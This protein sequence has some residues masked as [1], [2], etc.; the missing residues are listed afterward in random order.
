M[1]GIQFSDEVADRLEAVYRGRDVAAQREDTLSRLA[2]K[3]GEHVLDIGSGPGFLCESIAEAVG[4]TGRV[5][6]VDISPDFVRRAGA[7]NRH[8]QLGYAVG[9]ATALDE[10]DAA[11]DVVVSTQVAEYV[12][13]IDAFCLEFRRVMKPGGRGLIIATD[14]DAVIWFSEHPER[15]ARMLKIWE[16]HCADPRLPRHLGPRLRAAGLELDG[17]SAFPLVNLRYEEGAYSHGVSGFIAG[18]AEKSGAV[19]P[20]EVADWKAELPELDAAGRYFFASS[21]FVFELRRPV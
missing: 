4:P 17:L 9:D 3:P 1:A 6:G 16:G 20:Q 11:Y 15:M 10:P 5:R 21:R 13:D 19:T 18:F 12:P 14:W 2:L 7:R 8:D